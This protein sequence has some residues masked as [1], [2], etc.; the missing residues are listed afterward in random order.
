MVKTPR[1]YHPLCLDPPL[2]EIPEGDWFCPNCNKIEHIVVAK[3][4]GYPLWPARIEG[5]LENRKLQ[6][7]FFGTHDRQ[8][9]H[10]SSCF[11]YIDKQSE[12]DKMHAK[13]GNEKKKD[14]EWQTAYA[15]CQK[16]ISNIQAIAQKQGIPIRTQPDA[17]V[18]IDCLFSFHI[19]TK[20]HLF[21]I[22][23]HTLRDVLTKTTYTHI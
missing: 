14:K 3:V 9:L 7:Y 13:K 12:M 22:H 16:Y 6:L 5:R 1:S 19:D 11:P 15:E 23:A 8:S 17:P 18:V 4:R 20:V 21:F 10:G 2:K